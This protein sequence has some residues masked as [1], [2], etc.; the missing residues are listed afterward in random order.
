MLVG[1]FYVFISRPCIYTSSSSKGS[2]LMSQGMHTF[3]TLF[4]ITWWCCLSFLI[5]LASSGSFAPQSP[6]L[7][8]CVGP[9]TFV[10]LDVCVRVNEHDQVCTFY[11]SRDLSRYLGWSTRVNMFLALPCPVSLVSGSLFTC[12]LVRQHF[13][14]KM[15]DPIISLF[16]SL[17]VQKRP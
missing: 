3:I 14:F 6:V 15:I 4:I 9:T 8:K 13:L 12:S 7:L 5:P 11:F 2:N 16:L 17:S 10:G 1:S